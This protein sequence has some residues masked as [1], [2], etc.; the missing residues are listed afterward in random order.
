MVREEREERE[1]SEE[2]EAREE[3]WVAVDVAVD[4]AGTSGRARCREVIWKWISSVHC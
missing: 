3:R 1:K 4:S 2:R